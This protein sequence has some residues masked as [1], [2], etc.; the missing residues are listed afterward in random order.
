M[1]NSS[2]SEEEKTPRKK[3]PPKE[4]KEYIYNKDDEV[5]EVS[6]VRLFSFD[7][8]DLDGCHRCKSLLLRKNLIH[9][10]E[11]IP[12]HLAG[13]LEEFDLFDNKVKKIGNFFQQCTVAADTEKDS[14]IPETAS[15]EVEASTDGAAAPKPVIQKTVQVAFPNLVRLD[16]SYN[17]IKKI[18]GLDSLGPTLK[19]LYLVE[20][21]IKEIAGLD[22]LVHLELLELGGNRIRRI[23]DGLRNLRSL[24]QL[25]LGKNKIS[26]MEDSLHELHAL[27]LLSLQAN[28][29]TSIEPNNLPEG[30]F[31]HLKEAFFS[32]NGIQRIENLPL[33]AVEMLDFSTNPIESINDEV[34]NKVN[35]PLLAE[36]WLTDGKIR[37]WK[38]VEKFQCFSSTMH[39]VYLERNPIEDDHRYRD[40]VYMHLPFLTQ[41]DSWPI[42]NKDNLEA[43]RSIQRR[44]MPKS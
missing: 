27:E 3:S 39:T 36:F 43:D 10:L 20:N 18:S 42:V 37:D 7:E 19:E 31:P 29:L 15:E 17:Q 9:Y 32:E 4:K 8:L 40:K 41:I 34:I 21:K 28:R 11:P 38:E 2:D 44:G 6:N 12:E 24:K 14:V 22:A 26:S 5:I 35:M 25:W 16:F 30:A 1:S 33:H 23:G 13:R